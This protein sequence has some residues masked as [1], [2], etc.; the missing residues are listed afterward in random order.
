VRRRTAAIAVALL[1]AGCGEDE[2]PVRPPPAPETE[3]TVTVRPREAGGEPRTRTITCTPHARRM[4]CLRL[5]DATVA[6]FAP[7]PKDT[8]CTAIYGG[9]ATA[10]VTGRL[11]GRRVDARFDLRNGCEIAR[12]ER[13]AWLLGDPPPGLGHPP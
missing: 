10:A 9:P 6:A 12:W 11:H 4:P 13:L 2:E 5:Q 1:A 7:V 3:L 8:A